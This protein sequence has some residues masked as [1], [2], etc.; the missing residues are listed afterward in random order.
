MD[1]ELI[2]IAV[3]DDDHSYHELIESYC[4]DFFQEIGVEYEFTS[5]YSGEDILNENEKDIDLLF[6]D[7]EMGGING[8][9]TMKRIESMPNIHRIIFISCHVEL[10]EDAFGYKPIGF[11]VKPLDKDKIYKKLGELYNKMLSDSFIEFS[12]MDS[13]NLFRK[14]DIIYIKAVSNYIIL[15]T[16]KEERTITCTLKKCAEQVNGNPFVRIHK[17]YIINLGYVKK[18]SSTQV[19]LKNDTVF[20][21]GRSYLATLK[22]EYQR[23]LIEE[24]NS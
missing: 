5:Y 13:N 23:Y 24:L 20:P 14:S 18:I 2:S 22:K 4:N 3:C 19:F 6:L 21:I 17:S 1:S 7:I 8:I 15:I 12:D 16:N 9:E 11:M 10:I